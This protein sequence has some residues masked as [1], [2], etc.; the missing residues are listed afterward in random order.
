LSTDYA[1]QEFPI[2]VWRGFDVLFFS[3]L[4]AFVMYFK[5]A[6]ALVYRIFWD[7]GAFAFGKAVAR[8]YVYM[9][10]VKAFGAV[11]R[12]AVA[13]HFGSAVF[14]YKILPVPGKSGHSRFHNNLVQ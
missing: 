9:L 12:I 5:I 8:C 11:V 14:A 10:A 7:H 6:V 2:V 3:A 4:S 1:L 13:L